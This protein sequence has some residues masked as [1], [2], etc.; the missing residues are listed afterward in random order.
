[1]SPS[2]DVL[3]TFKIE[4]AMADAWSQQQGIRLKPDYYTPRVRG[5]TA[6]C[7]HVRRSRQAFRA[8]MRFTTED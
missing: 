7:G 2:A 4:Q 8:G 6:R 1:M 5:V 3:E